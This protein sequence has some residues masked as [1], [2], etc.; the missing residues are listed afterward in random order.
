MA[1]KKFDRCL[2]HIGAEKTGSTSLQRFFGL[3]RAALSTQGFFIPK[4]LAPYAKKGN[5]NHIALAALHCTRAPS[6]NDLL[7]MIAE[8]GGQADRAKVAAELTQEIELSFHPDPNLPS[9]LLL[10]NEHIH[11]RLRSVEELT[12]LREFLEQ[13]ASKIEVIIYI[14]AQHE[15][16]LSVSATVIKSGGTE[17][18]LFPNFETNNGFDKVLGVD[19]YYFDYLKILEGVGQVFG[20]DNLRVRIFEEKSLQHANLVDDF[21]LV[22]GFD[23]S[24]Y[25]LPRKENRSFD[26]QALIVLREINRHLNKT[27]ENQSRTRELFIAF[28]EEKRQGRGLLPSREDA[29]AFYRSFESSNEQVQKR[30]FP[31]KAKLFD[32]DFSIYP[33]HEQ[34]RTLEIADVTS[35]LAEF[36]TW[37]AV[38]KKK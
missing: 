2:L 36:L 21:V 32:C 34:H 26:E 16:S 31:S 8:G 11:S 9:T 29:E 10:S 23:P 15:T 22:M 30:W 13:F 28:L 4:S 18:R 33:V 7:Q 38:R 19:R 3:N 14:R 20:S 6:K 17:L 12:S 37:D 1:V 35:L 24:K 27:V 5:F 25:V